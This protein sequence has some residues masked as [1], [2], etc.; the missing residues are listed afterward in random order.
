MGALRICGASKRGVPHKLHNMLCYHH[1]IEEAGIEHVLWWENANG[2]A[3]GGNLYP[4]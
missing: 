4:S 2:V 3:A 1:V